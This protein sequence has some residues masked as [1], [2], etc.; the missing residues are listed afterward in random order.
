MLEHASNCK[1]N[2]LSSHYQSHVTQST[3]RPHEKRFFHFHL[4]SEQEYFGSFRDVSTDFQPNFTLN[5]HLFSYHICTH[6]KMGGN[7]IIAAKCNLLRFVNR[8]TQKDLFRLPPHI[9]AVA[10][11]LLA[12]FFIS[13][14]V[15]E[16]RR[17]GKGGKSL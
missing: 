3:S 16:E 7:A 15:D 14:N 4:A 17:R 8:R 2:L 12:V 5:F 6:E 13:I 1:C 9:D 10:A 11:K